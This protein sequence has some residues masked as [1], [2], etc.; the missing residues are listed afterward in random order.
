[1]TKRN[2]YVNKDLRE[3]FPIRRVTKS[4]DP[5]N[6]QICQ[7]KGKI[8]VHKHNRGQKEEGERKRLEK[9]VEAR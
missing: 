3:G 7:A 5:G 2:N 1:M 9:H 8:G 4:R 6:K